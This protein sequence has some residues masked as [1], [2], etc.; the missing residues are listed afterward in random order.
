M[1][2]VA[3]LFLYPFSYFL[4]GA[5]Y[6]DALFLLA[7]VGAFAL[8][9]DDRPVLAGL[10]GAVATA[11]RPV[12]IAVAVGLVAV[13]VQRRGGLN[14]V[15]LKDAG[16][17]LAGLG[18]VAYLAYLAWRFGEPLAFS[19]VQ[20]AEGWNRQISFEMIAKVDFYR[21]WRD[22]GP[23]LV[24]AALTLQALLAIGALA[25]VPRVARRLGWGYAVY[26]VAVLGLPLAT[27]SDFLAMGR[28]LLPAFPVFAVAGE[29][30]DRVRPHVRAAVLGASGMALIWLTTLFARWYLLS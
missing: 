24:N 1:T 4:F 22:F 17:L 15:R 6:S 20:T 30:L 29:V 11:G 13:A 26:V 21:R 8:L 23:T 12:G 18:F 25:L 10:A 14:K 3:L 5:V 16:V 19:K 28:Y 7:A 9:E 27:S 2:A